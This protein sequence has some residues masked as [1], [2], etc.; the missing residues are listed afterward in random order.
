MAARKRGIDPSKKLTLADFE[1][2]QEEWAGLGPFHSQ[3]T[4]TTAESLRIYEENLR[5]AT[6]N[7]PTPTPEPEDRR[8]IDASQGISRNFGR[9]SR[10]SIAFTHNGQDYHAVK[11]TNGWDLYFGKGGIHGNKGRVDTSGGKNQGVVESFLQQAE[12]GGGYYDP[13]SNTLQ[14]GLDKLSS[15]TSDGS[16]IVSAKSTE[17]ALLSS[18]SGAPG[19]TVINNFYGTGGNTNMGNSPE[20]ILPA[21]GSESTA[22]QLYHVLQTLNA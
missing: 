9:K 16:T 5:E 21:P 10:E 1:V 20:N 13:Q 3:T 22:T 7:Q 4:R 8:Q 19:G 15:A 12:S 18:A 14:E 17:E 11:T 2:L 6:E